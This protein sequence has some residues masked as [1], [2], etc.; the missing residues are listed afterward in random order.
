M[1][2]TFA[3][4]G[5]VC[6]ELLRLD[7][8]ALRELLTG[9]TSRKAEVVLDAGAGPGLSTRGGPFD[10]DGREAFGRRID[11]SGETG[12]AG[13]DDSDIVDDCVIAQVGEAE[14]IGEHGDGGIAQN[15]SVR[16]EGDGKASLRELEGSDE[17]IGVLIQF[18]VDDAVG[19][20]IAV[21]NR[22]RRIVSML[23]PWP[24]RVTPLVACCNK[25]EPAAD[26]GLH[27]EVGDLSL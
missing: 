4:D 13:A 14:L 5:E 23:Y 21:R 15:T 19:I 20:A 10:D 6:T 26:G 17:D 12:R 2:V 3:R 9:Y 11:G 8:C 24:R 27:D 25:V 18:G 1:L 7:E 22:C 16:Q